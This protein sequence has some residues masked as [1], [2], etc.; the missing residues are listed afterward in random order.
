ML[1]KRVGS[2][3]L[4]LPNVES[5]RPAQLII[6]EDCFQ[7]STT[8]GNRVA[9]AFVKSVERLFGGEYIDQM[10]RSMALLFVLYTSWIM[11]H[12]KLVIN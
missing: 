9:E 6:A 5:V 2:V 4:Q 11:D 8:P 10:C 12:L 7:L 1:L 3:L